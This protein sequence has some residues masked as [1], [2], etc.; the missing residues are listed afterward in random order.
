[1]KPCRRCPAKSRSVRTTEWKPGKSKDASRPFVRIG[2]R[3]GGWA[4][5]MGLSASLSEHPGV[6]RELLVT[7]VRLF[8]RGKVQRGGYGAAS[9]RDG[10]AP[11]L[12]SDVWVMHTRGIIQIHIHI[13]TRVQIWRVLAIRPPMDHCVTRLHSSS[14]AL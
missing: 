4:L 10:G 2:V 14:F 12:R 3:V 7:R 13:H 11:T 1:M 8:A 9:F 6:A 5:G